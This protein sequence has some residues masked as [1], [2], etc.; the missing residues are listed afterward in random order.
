MEQ[1]SEFSPIPEFL[2]YINLF[3]MPY[4]TTTLDRIEIDGYLF[5]ISNQSIS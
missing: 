2:L 4:G 3:P 1:L 5:S